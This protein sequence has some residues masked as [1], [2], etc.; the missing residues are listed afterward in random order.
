MIALIITVIIL[1]IIAGTAISIGLNGG[2]IFKKTDTTKKI[3]NTATLKEEISLTMNIHA[4]E[5]TLKDRLDYMPE[6][7]VEK[8]DNRDDICLVTKD[9]MLVTVYADGDMLDGNTSIWHGATDIE[10]PKIILED[11][12]YNWYIYSAGEFK[13]FADFVNNGNS[14]TGSANGAD[15][16]DYVTNNKYGTTTVSM[17]SSSTINLMVNI[18]LMAR[19]GYGATEEEKWANN[20][21]WTPIGLNSNNIKNNVGLLN[22]NNYCIKGIYVNRDT[23]YCGLYAYVQK[24]KD[25]TIKDGFIKGKNGVGGIAGYALSRKQNRKLS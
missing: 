23:N 10:C 17:T 11:G 8:I 25:I 18:D 12:I 4:D 2:E 20:Y 5:P 24:I 16:T 3:W 22:G 13:F 21:S 7:E 14:L 1:L 6:V 19:P 9:D 15:L